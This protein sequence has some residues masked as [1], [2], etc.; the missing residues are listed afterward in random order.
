[1]SIKNK[2]K[3]ILTYNKNNPIVQK[4]E[5]KMN[6]KDIFLKYIEESKTYE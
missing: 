4:G 2:I 1:M 5:N 3:I 6:Y